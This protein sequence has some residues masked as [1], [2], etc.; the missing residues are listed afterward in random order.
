MNGDALPDLQN[1]EKRENQDYRKVHCNL[2]L[3]FLVQTK[4]E[5][6]KPI[7]NENL[8][9]QQFIFSID[10]PYLVFECIITCSNFEVLPQI[11]GKVKP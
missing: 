10:S 1:P 5:K 2:N 3:V 4:K 6:K 8:N 7:N 9:D 11:S